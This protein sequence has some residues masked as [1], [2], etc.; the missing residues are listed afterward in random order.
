LQLATET[1]RSNN[2]RFLIL[3]GLVLFAFCVIQRNQKIWLN[4][5]PAKEE[6]RKLSFPAPLIA[7]NLTW[8]LQELPFKEPLCV[9]TCA[10][11]NVLCGNSANPISVVFSSNNKRKS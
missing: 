8:S 11:F 10:L 3:V 7:P 2:I 9:V 1:K 6:K 5:S 4:E